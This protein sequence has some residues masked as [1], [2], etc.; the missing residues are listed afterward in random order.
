M[1]HG[2]VQ[3]CAWV[4]VQ[5][6]CRHH[7]IHHVVCAGPWVWTHAC[8]SCSPPPRI[9]RTVF[10]INSPQNLKSTDVVCL[11]TATGPAFCQWHAPP[12]NRGWAPTCSHRGRACSTWWDLEWFRSSEEVFSQSQ[13]FP[14]PDFIF[15][16]LPGPKKLTIFFCSTSI[17]NKPS[18]NARSFLSSN[19]SLW[20]LESSNPAFR[21]L[22]SMKS[23][24][25]CWSNLF[26]I[27]SRPV[28]RTIQVGMSVFRTNQVEILSANPELQGLRSSKFRW[29]SEIR[30]RLDPRDLFRMP[31]SENERR[32]GRILRGQAGHQGVSFPS[33]FLS[34]NDLT[35]HSTTKSGLSADRKSR[36]RE[37]QNPVIL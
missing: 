36:W 33:D 13:V 16:D 28:F 32:K 17:E 1:D 5:K 6:T 11:W 2:S 18:R 14:S 30:T 21:G 31:A 10:M 25:W 34:S 27:L 15:S 4:W 24:N 8:M 7:C 9:I 3:F 20:I 19:W 26:N 23:R 22:K 37:F 29:N 12:H 35:Q